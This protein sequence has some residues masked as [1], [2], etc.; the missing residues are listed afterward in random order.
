S[1]DTAP[2][3]RCSLPPSV[4]FAADTSPLPLNT[5]ICWPSRLK[6]APV[7]YQPGGTKPLTT[8]RALLLTSATA[9]A[10]AS[11]VDTISVCPSGE[12][13][14][15]L[16]VEVGGAF[17]NRLI[18]ICSSAS[19]EKVS[20]TQ[21]EPLLPQATNSRLPSRDSNSAFGC[22]PV[23]NSSIRYSDGSIYTCTRALPH[24]DTYSRRPSAET[25][26]L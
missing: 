7:G 21:T 8:L 15:E 5:N 3:R 18:E 25:T 20:K 2:R 4:G 10:L 24:S 26:Q 14:S 23:L 17:G 1:A 11:A 9:T 12:S 16:G 13:A 22:S 6:M 19:A